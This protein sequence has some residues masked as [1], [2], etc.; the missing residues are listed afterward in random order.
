M[1]E[2]DCIKA[3]LNEM[4]LEPA[5]NDLVDVPQVSGVR[6]TDKVKSN[7]KHKLTLHC[8]ARCSQH[9]LSISLSLSLGHFLPPPPTETL[10][11]ILFLSRVMI[12]IA[13]PLQ[14][15][16]ILTESVSPESHRTVESILEQ[17]HKL[18]TLDKLLLYLKLPTG[19]PAEACDPLRQPLNPLGSRSDWIYSV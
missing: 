7:E 8:R 18:S 3:S 1:S 4:K 13:C 17:V 15:R 16:A 5:D 19:R 2:D 12:L 10:R 14:I 6:K 9:N 11:Y